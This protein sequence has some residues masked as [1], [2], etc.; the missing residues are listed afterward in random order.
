MSKFTIVGYYHDT[1]EVWVEHST[2][3]DWIT[4]TKKAVRKL[5]GSSCI[6]ANNLMIVSVFRGHLKDQ[7][8][9]DMTCY[10]DGFPFPKEI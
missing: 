9:C 2:G 6:R 7:N 5:N 3:K 4:A 10:A 1:N 8:E